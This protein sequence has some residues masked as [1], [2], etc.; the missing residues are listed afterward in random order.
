MVNPIRLYC[1][2]LFSLGMFKVSPGIAQNY[3]DLFRADYTGSTGNAFEP[4]PGTSNIREWLVDANIPVP[5][6]KNNTILTGFQFEHIRVSV[7]PQEQAV[8]VKTLGLKLGLNQRYS[9]KWSGS[10]FLFPKF[11]SDLQRYKSADFQF[12]I[13]VLFKLTQQENL[14]F[15]FGALYNTDLFGPFVT[16]LLGLYF[17]QAKWEANVLLPSMVDLNYRLVA[18][19]KVGLRFNGMIKSFNLNTNFNGMQ[20][21]LARANNEI[22]GYLAWSFGKV[23][24][25]GMI[26]YSI[27]RSYR[28][29][30]RDDRI[31]LGLSAIRLGDDRTQLNPDFKDGLVYKLSVLYRLN[32]GAQ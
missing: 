6:S 28:T 11:A 13:A 7:Y 32:T 29:Y 24:L 5:I 21:Y 3:I 22:G 14:H 20:Q 8:A 17:Q 26:G 19:L 30:A 10:Y 4:G 1:I 12:G 25:I 15:K 18:A 27:G 23:H 2:C 31:N 9:N 16:P